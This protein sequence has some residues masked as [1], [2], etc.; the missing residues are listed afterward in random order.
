MP[1]YLSTYLPIYLLTHLRTCVPTYLRTCLYTYNPTHLR[2]LAPSSR[3]TAPSVRVIVAST[4]SAPM[5][6]VRQYRRP[7]VE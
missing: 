2:S 6:P 1:T 7:Q 3:S 5:T 4:S